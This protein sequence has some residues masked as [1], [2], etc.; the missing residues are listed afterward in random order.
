[1]ST[2]VISDT[3]EVGAYSAALCLKSVSNYNVE[4]RLIDNQISFQFDYRFQ[5]DFR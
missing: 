4:S 2:S 3:V 1:M 5:I